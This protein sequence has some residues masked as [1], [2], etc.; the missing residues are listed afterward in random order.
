VSYD[1]TEFLRELEKAVAKLPVKPLTE[2]QIAT[3]ARNHQ[4][5]IDYGLIA[6]DA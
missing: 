4:R 2:A 1:D 5:L 3:R 6:P